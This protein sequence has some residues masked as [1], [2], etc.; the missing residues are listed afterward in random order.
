MANQTFL[1]FKPRTKPKPTWHWLS[2]TSDVCFL[3]PPTIQRHQGTTHCRGAVAVLPLCCMRAFSPTPI[4]TFGPTSLQG[5]STIWTSA[6]TST[7]PR[8]LSPT[9]CGHGPTITQTSWCTGVVE[10]VSSTR[11]AMEDKDSVST[12]RSS[13]CK[14]PQSDF[15]SIIFICSNKTPLTMPRFCNRS[16]SLFTG[17]RVKSRVRWCILKALRTFACLAMVDFPPLT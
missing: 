5:S 6:S 16:T 1:S 14:G 7:N 9:G 17:Q 12:Y 15:N 10:D 8:S 3:C 4:Q 11:S 2:S 13:G